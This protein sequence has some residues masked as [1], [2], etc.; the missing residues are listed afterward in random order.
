MATT[1]GTAGRRITEKLSDEALTASTGRGWAAWFAR[2]DAWGGTTRTHTEIARH[3]VEA[4]GLNGW[5]AQSV[6]VGYEQ[7]RGL[8]EVGQS[9]DGDWQA[10]A[11]RTVNAPAAR[12]TEAFV[13]EA[14]RRRWLPDGD[15]DVR[16][17]RPGKSLTADWEGATS[18]ISVYLTPKGGARTQVGLGH[19]KLPDADAVVAYK[20]FWRARLTD[21][22]N[23]LESTG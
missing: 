16:T 22:K 3:L 20:E 8:R 5:H 10:S 7:E 14:L 6:A 1:D 13:D 12:V 15:F 17:H 2:L 19:T 23:L 11:S 18:R 21:L 4:E 9:C